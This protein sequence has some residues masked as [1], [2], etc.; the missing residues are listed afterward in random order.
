MSMSFIAH[1]CRVT[2]RRGGM[3]RKHGNTLCILRGSRSTEPARVTLRRIRALVLVDPEPTLAGNSG[4]NY[5]LQ[6]AA[7]GGTSAGLRRKVANRKSRRGTGALNL[8]CPAA[9][10]A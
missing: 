1:L 9:Q 7:P 2:L 3:H 10:S 8:T 4:L 6:W 5:R